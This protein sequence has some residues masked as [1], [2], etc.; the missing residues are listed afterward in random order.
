MN[1]SLGDRWQ[2]FVDRVVA[3]GRYGSASEVVREGLRLLEERES[4]LKALHAALNAAIDE[5]GAVSE[6]ELDAC[7]ESVAVRL[8]A[9]GVAP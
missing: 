3:E 4:R 2:H 8:R 9:G 6:K 1:A 5:G 7:L